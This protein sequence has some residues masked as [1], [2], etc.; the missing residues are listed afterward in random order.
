MNGKKYFHIAKSH[1]EADEYYKK[2][3]LEKTPEER[4]ED[5]FYLRDRYRKLK[6]LKRSPFKLVVQKRTIS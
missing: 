4:I 6:G 1:V 2:M 5:V 3:D